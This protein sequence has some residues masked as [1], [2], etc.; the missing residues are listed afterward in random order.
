MASAIEN[1]YNKYEE[2][3][4]RLKYLHDKYDEASKNLADYKVEDEATRKAR[5]KN[6][7][8]QIKDISVYYAKVEYFREYAER[9]ITSKNVPT[10][11]A[12]EL[13]FNSLRHDA[14]RIDTSNPNDPYAYRLYVHAQ[15]NKIYLMRKQKEF[16]DKKAELE[17]GKNVE[18]DALVQKV[19]SIKAQLESACESYVRSEEFAKFAKDVK[20][21][22]TKYDSDLYDETKLMNY[23]QYL[24]KD[25]LVS[26]GMRA[27]PLPVIGKKATA[28]VKNLLSFSDNKLSYYDEKSSNILLPVDYDLTKEV[29]IYVKCSTVKANRCF[30]GIN[31]FILN[32]I[33][34]TTPGE[35][36]LTINFVD[37]LHYNNMELKALKPIEGTDL[38]AKVPQSTEDIEGT[39][40][41]I[42]A[43]FSDIDD[44]LQDYE[45]VYEY[46]I[47]NP[48][49]K[50]DSRIMVLN[51]YPNAYTGEAR[52]SIE[53]IIYN[54]K[55]YGISLVLVENTG[56]DQSKEEDKDQRSLGSTDGVY[57]IDMPVGTTSTI[58]C[59]NNA[60]VGFRWY[61]YDYKKHPLPQAYVD[62][63]KQETK[64][65]TKTSTEYA[66]NF[67]LD[68][69]KY[70]DK[71][72]ENAKKIS[73][74]YGV[75]GKGEIRYVSF[76]E[77]NFA[78][79][80]MGASGSGKSTLLHTLI[81]GIIRNYH[82]DDVELWLADFKMA[83]F[84]QYIDPMPPHVK[85]ILLD[86]SEELIFDLVDKLSNIM[87]ER[88]DFFMNAKRQK[89]DYTKVEDIPAKELKEPMPIIFVILDEFSIMSQVL[90]SGYDSYKLKLQ[91]ILAKGRSLGIKIIFSSQSFENGIQGLTPTAKEQIQSRIAMKNN[92]NEIEGTLELPSFMKTEENKY[93][94]ASLPTHMA[95]RKFR[96]KSDVDGESTLT[97]E[98]TSV[99]YF[100]GKDAYE[101]QRE[102]IESI[103]ANLTAV[104]DYEPENI[105]SYVDKHP[106]VVDGNTYYAFD[107]KEIDNRIAIY[108]EE[109]KENLNDDEI[110]LYLGRPRLMTSMCDV[111]LTPEAR[112][113]I[114]LIASSGERRCA[115]SIITTCVK[116]FALQDNKLRKVRIWAYKRNALYKKYKDVWNSLKN[117]T[118]VSETDEICEEI[119][120][121]KEQ[122]ENN[123]R[124][125]ELIVLVGFESLCI[126]FGYLKNSATK[127]SVAKKTEFV[128][129]KQTD[130]KDSTQAKNSDNPLSALFE[131]PAVKNFLAEDDV[132]EPER[133]RKKIYDAKN[134]LISIIKMGSR[135]GIHFMLCLNSYSDIDHIG[136]STDEFMHKM[137][138]RIPKDDAM[139]IF[140]SGSS[141]SVSQLPDHVCMYTDSMTRFSF[142]PY[143]HENI[144]WDGW[145]LDANGKAINYNGEGE[146]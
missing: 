142:R 144:D 66:K 11:K 58:Q 108:K 112:Q 146:I 123:G 14:S 102:M 47:D 141:S 38:L 115:A 59:E 86:E 98:R 78:S 51:G 93:W 96:E 72:D 56:Y 19:D 39:L 99:M 8:K 27:Q 16:E 121:L 57:Y 122:I 70:P 114:L 55:R 54:H 10:L 136:V 139:Y 46:N 140:P 1:L 43:G 95:L 50:L 35:R 28:M 62:E 24:N 106:V 103:K 3:Y 134:D 88:Q 36:N 124:G 12:L 52:K 48:D 61:E 44:V 29:C 75:D 77:E 125:D 82:P 21:I 132:A 76:G 107:K 143:I 116:V 101:P 97:L 90:N 33:R 145:K 63:I 105:N 100:P 64:Q 79:Y 74:P 18:Y 89:K 80:L 6:F 25:M 117:V 104:N 30:R 67:P 65:K 9:N 26:F 129:D 17:K 31:S 53:R 7:E 94:I 126:E 15:C 73:L 127:S 128:Q 137:A 22:H 92:M 68:K 131:S 23:H 45:S 109:Q 49:S 130:K 69:W 87:Y 42:V 40:G 110:F 113:N 91:N 119:R 13:D 135:L 71:S 133:S 37:A 2:V 5:I 84:S 120:N 32:R 138:F 34:R 83:E 60:K 85:Y 118:V 20:Y 81:T 41:R 111:I 4:T